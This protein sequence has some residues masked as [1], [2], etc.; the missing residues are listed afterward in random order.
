MLPVIEEK[1]K[2]AGQLATEHGVTAK[3]VVAL[4]TTPVGNPPL[5]LMKD[6]PGFFT[7][8]DP[9]TSPR[10]KFEVEVP[11]LATQN[12][13]VPLKAIPHGLTSNGSCTGANPGMSEISDVNR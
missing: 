6:R 4:P 12:G 8:G 1:M 11:L 2:A 3:S 13:L 5:M 7:S 10:Y 9:D